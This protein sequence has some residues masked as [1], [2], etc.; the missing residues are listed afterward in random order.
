[1]KSERKFEKIVHSEMYEVRLLITEAM[2]FV[3]LVANVSD[4][5]R[6]DIRLV[7]SELLINALYHGNKNRSSKKIRLLIE[8][9]GNNYMVVQVEDE[10]KGLNKRLLKEKRKLADRRKSSTEESGRGLMLISGIAGG[11]FTRCEGRRVCV[12]IKLKEKGMR[13]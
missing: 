12:K 8:F 3:D 9:F 10:G 11:L 13:R 2:Q 4:E 6:S 7:I 5:K 1:M